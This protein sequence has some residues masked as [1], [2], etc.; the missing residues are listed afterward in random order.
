M[1]IFAAAEGGKIAVVDITKVMDSSTAVQKGKV[2]VKSQHKKYQNDVSSKQQA[3]KKE[4]A[5]LVQ[6]VSVLSN[7]DMNEKK[8]QFMDEV[9]NAHKEVQQNK[10]KLDT[11]NRDMLIEVQVVIRE[12]VAEMAEEKGLEIVLPMEPMIFSS[13]NLDIT[14]EVIERLN[15]KLPSLELKF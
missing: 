6:Q 7:E 2:E 8:K 1:P 10:I 14:N 4:E 5:A 11:A 3:L 9:N 12:V 15:K 13:S